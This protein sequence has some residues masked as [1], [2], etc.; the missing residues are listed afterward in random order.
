VLAAL[1]MASI[2]LKRAGLGLVE[3]LIAIAVLGVLLA[4]AVPSLTEFMERR[5]IAAVAGELASI[6][7]YAKSETNTIGDVVTVHMENDPAHTMSCIAVT[8]QTTFDTCKCYQSAIQICAGGE[9]VSLRLFQVPYEESTRFVASAAEWP[10]GD[11]AISVSRNKHFSDIQGVGLTVT[12]Q[13]TA[14]QL[15]VEYNDAGRVRVCSPQ[16]SFSGYP[17]C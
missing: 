4:V 6:L 8:T 14:A 17:S 16:G 15:R 7:N 13:H 2:P 1:S 9:S 3:L 12:G 11:R 10:G 5:R